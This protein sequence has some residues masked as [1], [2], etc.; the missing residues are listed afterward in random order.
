MK[1]LAYISGFSIL[2][3]AITGLLK[4]PQAGKAMRVIIG[5]LLIC[6]M[7]ECIAMYMNSIKMN[8]NLVGDLFYI[9]EGLIFISFFY[10][11]YDEKEFAIPA[12]LLALVYFAYGLFTT[13]VDPGYLEYNGN[14]RAAESLMIQALTAYALIK[15]SKQEN[16]QLLQNPEFWISAGL[17]IYFSVNIAVFF[18]AEFLFENNVMLM[19]KTWLIHSVVNIF[20]NLIFT[21]GLICIPVSQRR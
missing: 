3:P 4:F 15:I 12:V 19:R 21:F 17:F 13:F 1:T 2:L 16:L 11:V 14:F 20:A 10:L 8:N 7:V 5:Y 6:L 18:T 9:T